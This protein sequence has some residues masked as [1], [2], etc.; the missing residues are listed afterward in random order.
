MNPTWEWINTTKKLSNIKRFSQITMAK[1]ENVLEHTG[2]VSFFALQFV[3][4]I[5]LTDSEKLD[6]LKK[7]L[8]HDVEESEMGDIPRPVKYASK[9]IRENIADVEYRKVLGILGRS[10]LETVLAHWFHAKL[11]NTGRI[12]KYCDAL[13]ALVTIHDEVFCRSNLSMLRVI[14]EDIFKNINN[15]LD[16]VEEAYGQS[17]LTR[18]H[19]EIIKSIEEEYHK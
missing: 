14:E 9:K 4:R 6:I 3:E 2:F 18:E 19:R 12:I 1:P 7:A 17:E 16:L 10:H 5:S 15:L 13:A 8:I 11:D